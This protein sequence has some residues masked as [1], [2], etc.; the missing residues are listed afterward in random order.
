MAHVI[1]EI[2]PSRETLLDAEET[3]AV[4]QLQGVAPPDTDPMN[5][6]RSTPSTLT[7]QPNQKEALRC[8][9]KDNLKRTLTGF[10]LEG[11]VCIVTGGASGIGLE[12]CRAI[13]SSG[14]KVALVDLNVDLGE[15]QAKSLNEEYAVEDPGHFRG[16][17][18]TAHAADV[19]SPESIQSAMISILTAHRQVDHLVTSA[20]ICENFP[21][22]SYP[23][24]RMQKL[25]AINIDGSFNFATAVARHL[26]ERKASGNI[27]IIASMSGSI[28]NVPQLQTPYNMSKAAVKHMVKSLGVEWAEFGI[29]VNCVSPGYIKTALTEKIMLNDPALYDEWV[30]RTPL[31]RLGKPSEIAGP[32]LFLLSDLSSYMTGSEMLADG[33]YSSI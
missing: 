1:S 11:K 28:V 5:A 24:V 32:V 14:G 22:I 4:L 23:Y 13:L 29:R 8:S 17:L 21:A 30:T 12:I 10:G 9:G 31:K 2:L 25:W 27:V 26:I 18:I 3:F 20:G 6:L 7:A 15:Q 33:G 16:P 19:S